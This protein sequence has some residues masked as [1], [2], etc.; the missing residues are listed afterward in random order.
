[1]NLH[2]MYFENCNY[3]AKLTPQQASRLIEPITRKLSD[4]TYAARFLEWMFQASSDSAKQI[5]P[6]GIPVSPW[7]RT[8]LQPLSTVH[9]P[10]DF[11]FIW[12]NT[13]KNSRPI[14]QRCH[15]Q[16]LYAHQQR[17]VSCRCWWCGSTKACPPPGARSGQRRCT[18]PYNQ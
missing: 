2:R 6:P 15:T 1:M 16:Y 9:K 12:Q 17:R 3:L 13:G 11:D 5:S 8:V 7:L 10:P 18:R 14:L 4:S